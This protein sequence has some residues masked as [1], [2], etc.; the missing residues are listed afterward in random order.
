MTFK[1]V[2]GFGVAGNFAGHLEQAGEASDFLTVEVKE[3]I[4]PKAIFPFY[5]PSESAGFLSI[6]PLSSDTIIPP[7]DADNLQIEPEVALLCEI[8]YQDNRVVGL[9]PTRFAAY[10]D[11]SIRKPNA[12][13]ISEKKNW[14]ANSKGVAATMIDIDGLSQGGMLDRYRIASFHKRG[15]KVSR[16][17]ED[18]PVVGYSY[19]HEKLLNW[20]VDRMNHQQDV[21]PTENIAEH[22]ANANYP[23][24]ALISIGATRYTEYGETHFLQSGDT[25]IVVVY[26]S[27]KYSQEDVSR[28]ATNNTFAEDSLST[29]VQLV[30]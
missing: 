3:Q 7:N 9:K 12:K 18:S 8:E 13:K 22:L 23:E 28:M 16:Y 24:Q 2:I 10:N 5:V 27:D 14:G 30:A 4:Q 21:G 11:C 1:R 26:D 19:F 17:G 29:L 25:S 20:I 15:D 6:Y